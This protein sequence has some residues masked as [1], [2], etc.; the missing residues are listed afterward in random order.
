MIALGIGGFSGGSTIKEGDWDRRSATKSTAR[1]GENLPVEGGGRAGSGS[2][3]GVSA[4]WGAGSGTEVGSGGLAG[5]STISEGVGLS[6]ASD[7][8]GTSGD[9]VTALR[10]GA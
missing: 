8:R 6:F 5:G 7:C 9:D 4:L 3:I 10:G 2:S 1:S